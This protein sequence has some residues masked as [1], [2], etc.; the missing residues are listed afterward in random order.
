MTDEIDRDIDHAFRAI[1]IFGKASSQLVQ[2]GV[3]ETA[4]ITALAQTAVD[5]R[6]QLCGESETADWLRRIAE[7]IEENCS[8]VH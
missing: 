6:I 7:K 5:A 4:V 8:S 2:H 3:S 1:E